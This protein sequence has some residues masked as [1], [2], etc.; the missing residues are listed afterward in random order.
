MGSTLSSHKIRN[1]ITLRQYY[2]AWTGAL[3][4]TPLLP[5]SDPFNNALRHTTPKANSYQ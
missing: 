1:K 5:H 2:T 3:P 4:L